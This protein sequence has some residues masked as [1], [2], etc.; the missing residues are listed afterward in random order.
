MKRAYL[1]AVGLYFAALIVFLVTRTFNDVIPIWFTIISQK[2]LVYMMAASFVL[3]VPVLFLAN[4]RTLLV[5]L[6]AANIA[7]PVI[8]HT[9]FYV[10]RTGGGVTEDVL[11]LNN[12]YLP[13]TDEVRGIFR[14]SRTSHELWTSI[15]SRFHVETPVEAMLL[16]SAMFEFGDCAVDKTMTGLTS[17]RSGC[18][19]DFA[20]LLASLLTHLGYENDLV[21]MPAHVANRALIGGNWHYLDATTALHISGFHSDSPVI[22]RFPHPSPGAFS[23]QHELITSVKDKLHHVVGAAYS[24][25]PPRL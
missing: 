9:D 3:S 21:Q 14:D 7:I 15:R 4:S 10:L 12:P 13:Y 17:A 8:G 22:E 23:L 19:T 6:L 2:K 24:R 1:F 18:C 16:V 5:A 11:M 25:L 20:Y